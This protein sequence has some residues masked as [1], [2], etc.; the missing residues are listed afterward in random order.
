MKPSPTHPEDPT[1]ITFAFG[2]TDLEFQALENDPRV[3]DLVAARLGTKST[4]FQKRAMRFLEVTDNGTKPLPVPLTYCKARTHRWAGAD[5]VNLQNLPSGR[6][7]TSSRLRQ[8]IHAPKGYRLVV[9]DASQIEARTNAWLWGQ[10]DLLQIF[11]DNGDPYSDIASKLHGVPVNKK[12]PNAHLRPFGKAMVLGLGYGMGWKKFFYSALSGAISGDILNITEEE[13]QK[14]VTFYRQL[15]DK[16]VGGW[17]TL[18]VALAMMVQPNMVPY[19]VGPCKIEHQRI[20]MP[21]GLYM[22]YPELNV[23]EVND[24][25]QF[26]YAGQKKH[27][28]IWGSKFDENIVQSVARSIVAQQARRIAIEIPLALLVHDEVVGVVPEKDADDALEF[29]LNELRTPPDWAIGIPLDAE[30]GHSDRYD[31]K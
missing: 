27:I 25:V 6:K 31:V 20:L 13:A 18:D 21:N 4:I 14:A 7:G 10:E 23:Y 9:A 5:K 15:N 26:M 28:K 8:A 3:S 22:H 12:G 30:G 19:Y 2:K 16:I 24:R 17:N 1:K 11:R 29:M